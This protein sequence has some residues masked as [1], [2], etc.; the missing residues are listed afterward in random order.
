MRYVKDYNYWVFGIGKVNAIEIFG[1][2]IEL[3]SL[4]NLYRIRQDKRY[5]KNSWI[6]ILKTMIH[7]S[8]YYEKKIGGK[9]LTGV[10]VI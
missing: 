4:S 3:I 10:V 1:Y 6:K 5:V 7:K 8:D 9:H 2:T